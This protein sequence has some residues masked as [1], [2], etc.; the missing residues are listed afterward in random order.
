M[1]KCRLTKPH[2]HLGRR[3]DQH[4]E[5]RLRTVRRRRARHNS[6]STRMGRCSLT[7]LHLHL[8]RRKD[9]LPEQRL[10]M[11]AGGRRA[12]HNSP[13]T[14]PRRM[15]RCRLITLYQSMGRRRDQKERLGQLLERHCLGRCQ[16]AFR[17]KRLLQSTPFQPIP[18]CVL[19]RLPILK[20]PIGL[21]RFQEQIQQTL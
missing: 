3:R 9:Q 21:Q 17:G 12:R 10:P 18:I 4:P 6:R 11:V 1:R 16:E 20:T 14:R 15:G 5:L 2:L 19:G 7:T 8:G 13:S